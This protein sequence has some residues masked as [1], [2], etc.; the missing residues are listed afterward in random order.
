MTKKSVYE[1]KFRR[2]TLGDAVK[3]ESKMLGP[4]KAY[5]HNMRFC[6]K[7]RDGY[8]VFKNYKN[9]GKLTKLSNKFLLFNPE[10]NFWILKDYKKSI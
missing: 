6:K 9:R 5:S 7:Y 4:I 3:L 2:L 10:Y 8:K 1:R